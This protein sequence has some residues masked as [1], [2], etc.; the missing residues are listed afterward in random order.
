MGRRRAMSEKVKA[1]RPKNERAKSETVKSG[2]AKTEGAKTEGAK[3]EGMKGDKV[4]SESMKL[5][6]ELADLCREGKAIEA[7]DRFYSPSIVSIEAETDGS[8]PKRTEGFPAVRGKTEWWEKNHETHA[9]EVEGPW[10][11]GDRFIV[12]YKF[13]VTPKTGPMAGHRMKLDETA[14]YTVADGKVVQEEFFYTMSG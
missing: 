2:S 9:T 1:E 14:L 10:P 12:R 7:V 3:T 11:N 6:K 8:M 13:D 4:K 5:G